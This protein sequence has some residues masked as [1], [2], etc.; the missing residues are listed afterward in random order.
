[1]AGTPPA[2]T[3]N[4][5]DLASRY[6]IAV[7]VFRLEKRRLDN[8][9]LHS[10]GCFGGSRLINDGL[11]PGAGRTLIDGGVQRHAILTSARLTDAVFRVIGI[12]SLG[13]SPDNASTG[14]AD[15]PPL[16][17]RIAKG[18]TSGQR[19]ATNEDTN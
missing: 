18:L 4:R 19:D 6:T 2:A 1:M 15:E 11:I 8:R 7:Q 14:D 16:L 12:S 5:H 9:N 13:H 3:E 17:C 10:T